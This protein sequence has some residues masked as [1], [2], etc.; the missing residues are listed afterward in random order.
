MSS[1]NNNILNKLLTTLK[2]HKN[3][4]RIKIK[5]NS[6]KLIFKWKIDHLRDWWYE[7]GNILPNN[8]VIESRFSESIF[9]IGITR[10]NISKFTFLSQ[11]IHSSSN[12]K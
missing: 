6:C 9:I 2:Y 5:I 11:I 4:W 7:G 3:Y 10:S 8:W 12:L 1:I